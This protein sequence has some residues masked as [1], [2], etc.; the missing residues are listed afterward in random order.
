[1]KDGKQSIRYVGFECRPE[2]TRSLEFSVEM[3]TR[4]RVSMTFE[5]DPIF[6]TRENRIMVQE[7]AGIC[8]AKLKD[9]IQTESQFVSRF[10]ITG[11]DILQ[12]RQVSAQRPRP[13]T[14]SGEV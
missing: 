3:P 12:Y 11:H 13:T 5:F 2:G 4:E 6:F 8:Y 7:A 9:M 1:M 14:K 10:L